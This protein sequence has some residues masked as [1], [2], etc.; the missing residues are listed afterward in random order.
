MNL[1]VQKI[2][3]NVRMLIRIFIGGK[4]GKD[5]FFNALGIIQTIH[6]ANLLVELIDTDMMKRDP[7]RFTPKALVD[8]F[9][10]SDIHIIVGHLHQG[11]D[12]LC[13]DIEDLLLEYP[14]SALDPVFLQDKI[15]Y[16]EALDKDDFLPTLRISM[17]SVSEDDQILISI[18][19]L[20]SIKK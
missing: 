7:F 1:M 10:Q 6:G 5:S 4:A 16:L 2:I 13:W 14:A 18:A 19:D 12:H 15:K 17:P 8:W 9:L 3:K 11:L 20:E